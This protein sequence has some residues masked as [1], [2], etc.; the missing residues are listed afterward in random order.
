MKAKHLFSLYL[1]CA[2]LWLTGCQHK[3]SL[4][5][6]YNEKTLE[7]DLSA[8]EKNKQAT[9]ED[10]KLL[11]VYI[12]YNKIID[13]KI[14]KKNYADLLL[15][16]KTT[17]R[18]KVKP[19]QIILSRLERTTYDEVLGNALAISEE[20]SSL[21][22]KRKELQKLDENFVREQ[23][24]ILKEMEANKKNEPERRREFSGNLDE[25]GISVNTK[26]SEKTKKALKVTL[27]KK[28]TVKKTES[29]STIEYTFQITNTTNKKV[30]VLMGKVDI[31]DQNIDL[32]TSVDIECNKEIETKK[33]IQWKS[34]A[35]YP[36]LSPSYKKLEKLSLPQVI[37]KPQKIFFSDDTIWQ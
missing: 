13:Q 3:A 36:V 1:L 22:N 20:D 10:L 5:S 17:Q 35:R 34:E 4:K 15:E 2:T 29:Y 27:L 12:L 33:T 9:P 14:N 16:A 31:L 18:K 11:S 21:Y 37:W 7:A 6:I 24:K 8:I 30:K 28:Q 23:D 26:V 32:V 25:G 19:F